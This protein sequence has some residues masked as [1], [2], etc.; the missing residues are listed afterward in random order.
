MPMKRPNKPPQLAI[1]SDIV[2]ASVRFSARKWF[3]LNDINNLLVAS[4]LEKSV[5]FLGN[6]LNFDKLNY[7]H[8]IP[9]FIERAS[10]L[11]VFRWIMN[12]GL[13]NLNIIRNL[14]AIR[15]TSAYT[16]ILILFEGRFSINIAPNVTHGTHPGV[17]ISC[18]GEKPQFR[19]HWLFGKVST[20][21]LFLDVPH[22][23]M[24]SELFT[25]FGSQG[26]KY[27]WK[28]FFSPFQSFPVLKSTENVLK[29][30]MSKWELNA[31]E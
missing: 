30:D 31:W 8:F 25:E 17:L 10:Q 7:C 13:G 21:T 24:Y 18:N 28:S 2:Y 9:G 19:F 16:D 29:E 15:Q 11:N 14:S 23:S 5:G 1:K 27:Y 3:S 22:G 4:K 26:G 20:K 6:S 12:L